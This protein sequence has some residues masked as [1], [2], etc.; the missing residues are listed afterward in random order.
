MWC[1]VC[2]CVCVCVCVCV[3]WKALSVFI[4]VNHFF[5]LCKS[6]VCGVRCVMY[7]A[8]SAVERARRCPSFDCVC[9]IF[10]TEWRK[11]IGC[12]I[13]T[14]YF[15]QKSPVNSGSFAKN[16]LQFKASYGSA[17]PCSE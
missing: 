5:E 12:R 3:C 16:D 17:P 8:P 2:D 15:A 14:G 11:V 1:M 7:G 9:Q 4:S 10:A 6:F 13:F